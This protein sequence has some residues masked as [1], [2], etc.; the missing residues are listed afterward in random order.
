MSF[1]VIPAVDVRGGRCVRLYQGRKEEETVFS[2]D[3]VAAAAAWRD[4]GASLLHVVDLDGAFTGRPTNMGVIVEVAGSL[5]IPVEVGGG[6]RD[7]ATAL[8]YLEAGVSRVIVGTSAFERPQW[9]ACLAGELGDRLVVG[10]DVRDGVVA[11]SG[12]MREG[13]PDPLEALKRLTQAGVR[14]IIYTDTS[15]DG[16]LR[17]PNLEAI[18]RMAGAS[19]V[20]V[21]ASGGIGELAHI[22]RIAGLSGLGVE[23][24][25]VGMA[26]YRNR[27]TLAEAILAGERGE[28]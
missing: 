11:V 8:A 18:E 1:T 17:G 20:P 12:W 14:R 19:P 23:G 28:G 13:A 15:R 9:L 5:D 25:I 2:E 6:I 3:P 21:I 4:Q 26:L 10:L 22:E 16:T 7:T 24:V 27:F